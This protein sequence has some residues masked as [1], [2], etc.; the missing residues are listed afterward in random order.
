M[1]LQSRSL[2]MEMKDEKTISDLLAIIFFSLIIVNF[3]PVV[4]SITGI[5]HAIVSMS[6][7]IFLVVWGVIKAPVLFRRFKPA[8]VLLPLI[9]LSVL[10]LGL[11]L[12]NETLEQLLDTSGQFATLC[13]P[14]M[15]YCFALRDYEQLRKSFVRMSYIISMFT[16]FIFVLGFSAIRSYFSSETYAMSLGYAYLIPI[17]FLVQDYIAEKKIVSLLCGILLMVFVVAYGSRGPLLGIALFSIVYLFRHLIRKKKLVPLFIMIVT[18][19]VIM[20]Q[21]ELILSMILKMALKL[22]INSRT[23]LLLSYDLQNDSGRSYIQQPLIREIM[24]HPL[25][26]RG[27]NADYLLVGIYAH[28][29]VIELLYEFGVILGGAMILYLAWCVARTVFSDITD[30]EKGVCFIFMC[31]SITELLVSGSLWTCQTFWIW[32]VLQRNVFKVSPTAPKP[33]DQQTP[34]ATGT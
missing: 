24:A 30:T 2:S 29:I 4:A 21:Y 12:F 27:I 15:I 3:S 32:F 8:M 18:A 19:I 14:A 23:L 17:L 20:S 26:I 16:V 34:E 7:K 1:L 13:L 25:M 9:V 31:A 10:F 11:T 6:A 22:G 33:S 28:N 5:P